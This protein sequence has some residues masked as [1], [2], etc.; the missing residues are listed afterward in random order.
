MRLA[1]AVR[2]GRGMWWFSNRTD[3]ADDAGRFDLPRPYGTCYLADDAVAALIE[4]FASPADLEP[5]VTLADVEDTVVYEG[6]L[7]RPAAVADT[8][9]RAARVPK[10]LGTI[11][12][13]TLTWQWADAL[14]ADGRGGLRAWLRHDPAGSRTIAVF[15]PAS[16][17]GQLPDT[18]VW[19]EP[20]APEPASRW[21]LWLREAV[22][23]VDVPTESD[24]PEAPD[25]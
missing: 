21:L 23:L 1:R 6:V 10:E 17:P 3:D 2:R 4:T 8:T 16:A 5:V 18:D 13:Y 20:S 11:T 25:P 7:A 24:V 12:P 15:G 14:H 19:S 9:D 22:T